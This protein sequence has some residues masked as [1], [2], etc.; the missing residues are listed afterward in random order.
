M[1]ADG[2]NP[3]ATVLIV[4]DDALVAMG[5]RL[6]LKELGLVATGIARTGPEAISLAGTTAPMLVLMDIQLGN[7]GDGIAVAAELLKLYKLRCLFMSG[8]NDWE[9]QQRAAASG[10]LGFVR[11]PYS[12]AQLRKALD[13]ALQTLAQ[14][15]PGAG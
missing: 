3:P 6:F 11:K 14:T 5:L 4:E 8:S 12:L 15:A 13:T 2:D 7:G 1:A 9:L 10:G